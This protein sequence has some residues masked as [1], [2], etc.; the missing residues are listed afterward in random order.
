MAVFYELGDYRFD[1]RGSL[2]TPAFA[3]LLNTFRL[4]A[5]S[6]PGQMQLKMKFQSQLAFHSQSRDLGVEVCRAKEFQG[7]CSPGLG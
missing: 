1:R 3:S 6:H 4:T 2:A 5:G 7:A